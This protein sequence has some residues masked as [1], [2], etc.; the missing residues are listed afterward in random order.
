MVFSRAGHG[1]DV[2]A[3]FGVVAVAVRSCGRY[4]AAISIWL[5]LFAP[6]RRQGWRG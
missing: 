4:A 3:V 2:Q 5:F 6:V 1:G